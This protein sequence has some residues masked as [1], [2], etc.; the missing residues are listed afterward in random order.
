MKQGCKDLVAINYRC[1]GLAADFYNTQKTELA[2]AEK[3]RIRS[4]KDHGGAGL[5][6]L[7]YKGVFSRFWKIQENSRKLHVSSGTNLQKLGNSSHGGRRPLLAGFLRFWAWGS[8][9]AG[10]KK[11][12][13][14]GIRFLYLSCG[15]DASWR[16]ESKPE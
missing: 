16:W 11:E 7:I 5:K 2:N 14:E 8:A 15:G 1:E 9:G 4:E 3:V 6:N 10:E 12:D 13:D